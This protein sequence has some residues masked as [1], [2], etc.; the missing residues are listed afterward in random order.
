MKVLTVSSYQLLRRGLQHGTCF[1][2]ATENNIN[3][4]QGCVGRTSF[5]PWLSPHSLRE[6]LVKFSRAWQCPPPCLSEP[7]QCCL[8]QAWQLSMPE[9]SLRSFTALLSLNTPL[10][11]ESLWHDCW[12]ICVRLVKHKGPPCDYSYERSGDS[13]L[14]LTIETGSRASG[15]LLLFA[16]AAACNGL[17]PNCPCSAISGQSVLLT[18][19]HTCPEEP[20]VKSRHQDSEG[21]K[22]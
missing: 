3:K 12:Q 4:C 1:I 15:L 18:Q 10:G 14:V 8:F 19:R 2:F 6:G 16:F 5:S 22:Y 20:T 13:F 17:T 11:W 21:Y 7:R 9:S